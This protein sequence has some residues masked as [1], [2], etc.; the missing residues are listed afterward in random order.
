MIRARVAS[1][2]IAEECMAFLRS[3]FSEE[4][5]VGKLVRVEPKIEDEGFRVWGGEE[6]EGST[7][8]VSC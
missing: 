5:E 8:G 1:N 2:S 6:G 3:A 4:V 7:R